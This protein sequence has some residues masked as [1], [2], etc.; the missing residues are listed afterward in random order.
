[1][2]AALISTYRTCRACPDLTL[3]V[4]GF[5]SVVVGLLLG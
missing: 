1:M 2:S 3:T 4:L 5:A